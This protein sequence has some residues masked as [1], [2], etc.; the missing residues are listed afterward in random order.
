MARRR[1]DAPSVDYSE[2]PLPSSF[3]ESSH[4]RNQVPAAV[5]FRVAPNMAAA[6]EQMTAPVVDAAETV[7]KAGQIEADQKIKDAEAEKQAEENR[8]AA[9]FAKLL[10]GDMSANLLAVAEDMDKTYPDF[11]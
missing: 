9:E 5:G 2:S 10:S 4:R 8:K 6:A 11:N 3:G 7:F 1:L